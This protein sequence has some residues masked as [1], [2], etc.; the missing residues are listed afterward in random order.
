MLYE[1][2]DE[3]EADLLEI[4]NVDICDLY[5]GRMSIRRLSVLIKRLLSLPGRSALCSAVNEA[6][7]WGTS[8]HLLATLVDELALS[9][10]LFISANSKQRPPQPKPVRRPGDGSRRDS[11]E[12]TRLKAAKPV[13]KQEFATP[14]QVAAIFDSLQF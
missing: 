4:F 7:E 5:T 14:K 12:D 3:V 2:P 1:Y 8:E 6:A 11:S 13:K 9:N 10:Y